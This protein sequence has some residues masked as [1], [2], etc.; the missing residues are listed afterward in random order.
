MK[1]TRE[2][3]LYPLLVLGLGLAAT[4]PLWLISGLPNSDD[5]LTHVFNLFA[6]DQQVQL[7]HWFPLR[8]P[9]RG[10]GYGYAVL[11]YYPPLPYA[12]LEV[13]HLAGADY[14]LSFK[15]GLTVMAILAGFT[16][17]AL[18]RALYTPLIGLVV[19]WLYLFNPYF[20]AN[21]H[22]RGAL[23]EQLG[24]AVGPLLL[25]A[26][27]RSAQQP[28]GR[29]YL[30]ASLSVALLLLA[31]FV[32]TLLYFPFVVLYGLWLLIRLP[33]ITRGQVALWLLIAGL[34]GALL[35]AFYWLPAVLE[36]GGLRRFDPAAARTAYLDELLSIADLLRPT[37][38]NSYGNVH[39]MPELGLPWLLVLGGSLLLAAVIPTATLGEVRT[40]GRFFVLAGMLALWGVTVLAAPFW[41]LLPI[42][43]I[44]QFPFRWLG[45]AALFT[46]LAGGGVILALMQWRRWPGWLVASIISLFLLWY[47]YATLRNLP[48][49]PAQLRSASVAQVTAADITLAGLYA[50]EYDQADNWRDDCWFWAYEYIPA[51]S[52][53]SNCES[54]RDLIL[55]S[56]PLPSDLPAVSAQIQPLWMTANELAAH[57]RAEQAWTVSLHAFWLPGWQ[58]WIDEQPAPTIPVGP[59]GLV[60]LQVPAGEHEWKVSYRPTPLRRAAVW[61]SALVGGLWLLAALRYHP[62]LAVKIL[63]GFV[64]LVGF[65]YGRVPQPIPL[66]TLQPVRYEFEQ[67]LVL[68]GYGLAVHGEQL[69]LDLVWLARQ[70]MAES[71]KVFVH[72]IDDTGHL[73]TQ[74][75]SRPLRFASN[76][77]RWLPGQVILDEHSLLLPRELPPGEYQVRVGLYNEQTGQRLSVIQELDGAAQDQVLLQPIRVGE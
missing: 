63:V 50:Y 17:F 15:L 59:M 71:Y 69:R 20:Q 11:A 73:W 32:S 47:S 9:E 65:L 48:Q 45:P 18:G 56:P 68:Q 31:H 1:L 62:A 70:A 49:Q 53:L 22:I 24:M 33:S 21:L 67:K 57:S 42:I 19:A 8:F 23:A 37:L 2:D 76:T 66:P 38:V 28:G 40:Q 3:W 5:S 13:I 16:S 14:V 43:A 7:G 61:V 29:T 35:S 54:M 60:G 34:T 74:D 55:Q 77:N 10:L 75:D 72:V 64:L 58:A 30:I 26:I 6:F 39:Q 52:S 25:L 4:M 46:A 36:S 44:L 51:A 27:L 12:I 41:R